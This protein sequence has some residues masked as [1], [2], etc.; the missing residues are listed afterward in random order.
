MDGKLMKKKMSWTGFVYRVAI[1]LMLL[2]VLGLFVAEGEWITSNFN[3]F[4]GMC[5]YVSAAGSGIMGVMAIWERN[6]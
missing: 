2:G 1:T 5:V 3:P 4:V 6:K